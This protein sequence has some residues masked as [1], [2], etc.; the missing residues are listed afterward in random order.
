MTIEREFARAQHIPVKIRN[1]PIDINRNG[2]AASTVVQPVLPTQSLYQWRVLFYFDYLVDCNPSIIT[3]I[4]NPQL[5][6]DKEC[7]LQFRYFDHITKFPIPT[8]QS[9]RKKSCKGNVQLNM[10][11]V[12]YFFS[13]GKDVNSMLKDMVIDIRITEGDSWD[14]LMFSGRSLSL[15]DFISD[16][17]PLQ[18][19]LLPK[20]VSLFSPDVAQHLP[21][22]VANIASNRI[23]YYWN[24]L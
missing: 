18:T 21:L 19:V 22:Q 8:D 23:D 13:V 9:N 24:C 12:H 16:Y 5:F 20:C 17:C 7:Y 1:V 2:E 6:C 14:R 10:L 15:H 11:R 4:A 3:N